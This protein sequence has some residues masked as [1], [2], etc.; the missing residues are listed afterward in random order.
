MIILYAMLLDCEVNYLK[1]GVVFLTGLGIFHGLAVIVHFLFKEKFNDVYFPFLQNYGSLST[2]T[3]YY[4]R[5]YFF[6]LDYK[7]HEQQG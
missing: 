4:D 2:A 6:G 5:G 3:S 1:T 7:P